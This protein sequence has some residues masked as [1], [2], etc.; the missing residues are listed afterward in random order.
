MASYPITK[1]AYDGY[2][3]ILQGA[4]IRLKQNRAFLK[5]YDGDSIRI[6]NSIKR[7]EEVVKI[8]SKMINTKRLPESQKKRLIELL[9]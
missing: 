8:I 7:D 3:L 9:K 1:W 6:R 2:V 4:K 5:N